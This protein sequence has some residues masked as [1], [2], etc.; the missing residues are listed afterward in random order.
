VIEWV[1]IASCEVEK[2]ALPLFKVAL[3]SKVA[4]S[5]N[6]TVPVAA[7][8]LTVAVKV[9]LCLRFDGLRFETSAIVVL[10]LF[11]VCESGADALPE[12]EASPPYTAVIKWEPEAREEV[13][14]LAMPPTTV[15]VPRVVAPSLNVTVPLAE[16]GLIVA[17]KVTD[18]P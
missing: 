4:P 2:L 18:A 17:V 6:F 11:T 7:E 9:T 12:N 8:E 14:K 15:E 5:K 13:E 3:P 16:E 1:P 10:A